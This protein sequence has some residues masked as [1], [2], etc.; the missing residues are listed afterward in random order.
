MRVSYEDYLTALDYIQTVSVELDNSTSCYK[1]LKVSLHVCHLKSGKPLYYAADSLAVM[2][3]LTNLEKP[4]QKKT[5][6]LELKESDSYKREVK[7]KWEDDMRKQ[8]SKI[9]AFAEMFEEEL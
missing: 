8:R 6:K 1:G 4:I 7:K 9:A 5:T 3:G 2:L